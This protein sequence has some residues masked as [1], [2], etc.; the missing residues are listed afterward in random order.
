MW[1]ES[2]RAALLLLFS[3]LGSSPVEADA[4]EDAL[5]ADLKAFAN[6]LR[7]ERVTN[8]SSA[9]QPVAFAIR[10]SSGNWALT[11]KIE[12]VAQILL[13]IKNVQFRDGN[14][15]GPQD[16]PITAQAI[17][18]SVLSI[19][20]ATPTPTAAATPAVTPTP[21]AGFLG[22]G[23]LTQV[24]Q[25]TETVSVDVS[26]KVW[27]S[28]QLQVAG[29]DYV[30]VP[31]ESAT[32]P[33]TSIVFRPTLYEWTDG[34]P[35]QPDTF[36]IRAVVTIKAAGH[37]AEVS[38]P[39]S[40]LMPAT[41][42]SLGVGR[43]DRSIPVDHLPTPVTASVPQ[44]GIPT[45][46]F[47]FRHANYA[48]VEGSTPG[49]VHMF[50]P[51]DSPFMEAGGLWTA[52]DT[53]KQA[54][55]NLRWIAGFS[56]MLTKIDRLKSA[57]DAQPGFGFSVGRVRDVNAVE[58]ISCGGWYCN[59]IETEDTVSAAMFVGVPGTWADA[60]WH[61]DGKGQAVR[62]YGT[63]E[64]ICRVSTLNRSQGQLLT[65]SSPPNCVVGRPADG[66]DSFNDAISSIR[67]HSDP[68][69]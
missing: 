27:R 39:R 18:D 25:V 42:I 33:E 5:K 45:V 24:E 58:V 3:L 4:L 40:A 55:A 67:M 11:T 23:T 69:F 56:A 21:V 59:D 26:W 28:G 61:D 48:A 65:L 22:Q 54:A 62:F 32:S 43:D 34:T 10:P 57:A 17:I 2:R 35:P 9:G 8:P 30:H 38:L 6:G 41:L 16:Q 19:A 31:A 14:P 12:R 64:V 68:S 7:L 46:L 13:A 53:V 36:T 1:N 52:I 63:D 29:T 15:I 49:F 50:V 60:W 20:T 37:S 44:L 66:F 51:S 47:L